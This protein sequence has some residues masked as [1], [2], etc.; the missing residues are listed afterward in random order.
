MVVFV[1]RGRKYGTMAVTFLSTETLEKERWALL[2]TY[3]GKR[4]SS[5]RIGRIPLEVKTQ[6]V[7]AVVIE[8][9]VEDLQILQMTRI[10]QINWWGYGIGMLA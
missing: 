5:I 9:M 10:E 7:V 4:V 6:W 3:L 8:R 1:A 2:P